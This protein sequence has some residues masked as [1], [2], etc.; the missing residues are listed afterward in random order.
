SQLAALNKIDALWDELRAP[1]AIETTLAR[2]VQDTAR[3]LNI[4][5]SQIFPVSAQKGLVGKIKNDI[6]LV[7]RSG[8]PALEIKL[9]NDLISAK[10]RLLRDKITSDAGSI[11]ET[12]RA[13][14][15]ARLNAVSAQLV[16]LHA[17]SGKSQA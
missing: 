17:L 2:Q 12:T 4:P 1:A 10:Q 3:A 13:M 5:A 14:I 9:S 15:D 7:A 6:G 16:E 8:L 11:I